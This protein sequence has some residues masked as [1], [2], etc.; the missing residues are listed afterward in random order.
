[1]RILI[2][3][4]N[5]FI[6]RF[7]TPQVLA[8]GHHVAVVHRSAERTI[9]GANAIA[10]DHQDLPSYAGALRAF[11]PDVVVDLL[12]SSGRQAADLLSVFR[13]H[14]GRVVAISSM[15]VYRATAVMYGADA[16][17]LEALPLTEES[18]LR[19]SAL[20]YPPP[21]LA[22]LKGL[23]GWVDDE[24]DKVAVE[25]A[26][27]GDSALPMTILRL[28]MIHGPGDQLHRLFPLLK[29]MDDGRPA[30]PMAKAVAAWRGSRGYVEN[31]AA[32]IALAATDDRAAG[33]T[34]NV[35]DAE[36]LSELEWARCVAEAAGWAGA[37]VVLPDEQVPPYLR[38]PG[39]LEQ[40][41]VTDT[42]RIRRE[43]GY[44]EPVDPLTG[45]RRT[46]EWERRNPPPVNPAMFDYDAE[47]RAVGARA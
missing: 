15:D 41:W 11:R 29:R 21:V 9:P 33:R 16:G 10:A 30:I 18:A 2:L 23:F 22:M 27:Q 7:L 8:A 45:L 19:S 13:G 47:D 39:R 31:I 4:G 26:V 32:A 12:L 20:T 46:I 5:G 34:Y 28:P 1:M 17:P 44:A 37:L 3:G 24:Y 40:H 6:G 35:G 42:S 38:M 43:L 36:P 25:R 14:A